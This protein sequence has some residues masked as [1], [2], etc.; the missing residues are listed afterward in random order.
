MTG[1]IKGLFKGGSKKAEN[2]D[3]NAPT[4][5]GVVSDVKKTLFTKQ[6]APVSQPQSGDAFFLSPDEAKTFGDIDYMREVK[7]VERTF[8]KGK[9]KDQ[10]RQ[11][12]ATSYRNMDD[13]S[14]SS[15]P[16]FTTTPPKQTFAAPK[17]SFSSTTSSST[18]SSTGASKVEETEKRR[19]APDSGMDMFRN[20]AKSIRKG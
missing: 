15:T 14:F 5:G 1:F 8:P 16:S 6:E 2:Q 17:P 4:L 11:I 10:V 13:A 9:R 7:T 20:M 18:T 19:P 12:S 3:P